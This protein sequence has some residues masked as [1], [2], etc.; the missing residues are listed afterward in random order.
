MYCNIIILKKIIFSVLELWE[1][2]KKKIGGREEKN[3]K[4]GIIYTPVVWV[5]LFHK[6][7]GININV[8]FK[9]Y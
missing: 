5:I 8:I 3:K 4:I 1:E 7:E 9:N 6:Y 2:N